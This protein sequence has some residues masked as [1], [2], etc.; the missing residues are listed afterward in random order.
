MEL[1]FLNFYYQILKK[2]SKESKIN[3][4]FFEKEPLFENF[5]EIKTKEDFKVIKSRKKLILMDKNSVYNL[6]FLEITKLL[7]SRFLLKIN[8]IT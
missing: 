4:I 7:K 5:Y 3:L 2:Y 8:S 6:N 1:E